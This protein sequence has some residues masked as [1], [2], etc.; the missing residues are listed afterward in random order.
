MKLKDSDRCTY[1]GVRAEHRDHVVPFSYNSSRKKRRASDYNEDDCVPACRECN[2][3][4]GSRVFDSV[5]EKRDYIQQ[6]LGYKYR[7]IINFPDWTTDEIKEMGSAF[8]KHLQAAMVLKKLTQRRL[9]WPYV[10]YDVDELTE[11]V[12]QKLGTTIADKSWLRSL[13]RIGR[14]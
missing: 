7:S 14:K 4:A 2:L 13:V 5:E 3:T 6:K 10:D 1:C 9:S 12:L 8:R 11:G